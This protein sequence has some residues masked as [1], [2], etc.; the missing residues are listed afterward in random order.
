MQL[1]GDGGGGNN[2]SI[3]SG[4]KYNQAKLPGFSAHIMSQSIAYQLDSAAE[5]IRFYKLYIYI[6]L[7]RINWVRKV[8]KGNVGNRRKM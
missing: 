3:L 8:V 1:Y 5:P 6:R 7:N 2:Q 4:H